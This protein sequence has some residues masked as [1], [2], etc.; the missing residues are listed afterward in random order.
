[1]ND[2]QKQEID[3]SFRPE[4]Y[5]TTAD[6]T[7]MLLETIS[8]A[9]KRKRASELAIAFDTEQITTL[10]DEEDL[11]DEEQIFFEGCGLNASDEVD[12]NPLEETL[13]VASAGFLMGDGFGSDYFSVSVVGKRCVGQAAVRSKGHGEG[14]SDER[15][16]DTE[17]T[18][19]DD[20]LLLEKNQPLTLHE[21][22]GMLEEMIPHGSASLCLQEQFETAD[23]S[24]ENLLENLEIS[25]DS[26]FYPE[27]SSFFSAKT[28][29]W[30]QSVRDAEKAEAG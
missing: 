19:P 7:V 2:T 28:E 21:V 11:T 4:S 14:G 20:W 1:M 5:W 13:E 8:D 23:D 18:S 26:S 29:A 30:R 3:L 12:L 24:G 16:F 17:E 27:L 10:Y 22:A 6:P 9:A 25:A 15:D